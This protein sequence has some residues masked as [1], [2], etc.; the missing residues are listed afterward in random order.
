MENNNI[1]NLMENAIS[2][3]REAVNVDTVIGTPI[4]TPDG[5]TVIPIS[6]VS[7]GFATGGSDFYAKDAVKSSLAAGNGAGVKID[8]VGFLVIRGE[9]IRMI[10]IAPPANTTVDRVIEKA[11]ELIDTV[12]E[13]I[14]KYTKKNDAE[15]E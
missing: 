5:V 3:M 4:T 2:R 10:N 8:P 7:Y 9:N 1:G 11:P 12:E 15:T 6:R 14:R 13:L